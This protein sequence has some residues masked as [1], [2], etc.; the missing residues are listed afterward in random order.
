MVSG[1]KRSMSH[2]RKSLSSNERAAM[3]RTPLKS[4]SWI[5]FLISPVMTFCVN[6][7]NNDG[8]HRAIFGC[9]PSY[10]VYTQCVLFRKIPSLWLMNENV[11]TNVFSVKWHVY[12]FRF[13][14]YFL[15]HDIHLWCG[16]GRVCTLLSTMVFWRGW[17]KIAV[18]AA[19]GQRGLFTA[20]SWLSSLSTL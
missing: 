17:D 10:D 13:G 8:E 6:E 20:F 9:P 1:L 3:L 7:W 2:V 14:Y 5:L 18:V 19:C 15:C 12:L 16:V 11:V 4:I